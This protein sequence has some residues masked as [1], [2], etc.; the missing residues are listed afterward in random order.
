MPSNDSYLFHVLKNADFVH[1]ELKALP[2][3]EVCKECDA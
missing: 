1:S 2:F 3:M